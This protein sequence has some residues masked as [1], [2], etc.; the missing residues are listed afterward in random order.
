VKYRNSYSD[1][2]PVIPQMIEEIS[3]PLNDISHA[4][5]P[6][7]RIMIQI[8]SSW[9][10]LFDRNPQQFMNIYDATEE[11]FQKAE[12]RIYRS[13]EYPSHIT[14]GRLIN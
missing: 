9:F 6:G 1:P 2:E 8:Q 13:E 11:D 4:F 12:I 7:H 10:P 3:V 14:L 5:L